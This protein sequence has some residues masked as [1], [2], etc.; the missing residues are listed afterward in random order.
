M[1]NYEGEVV[2][3]HYGRP[4]PKGVHGSINLPG[5]T[6]STTVIMQYMLELYDRIADKDL[7]VRRLNV[8]ASRV[9]P[10]K[11][12]EVMEEQASAFEQMELFTDYDKLEKDRAEKKEKM[13]REKN[14][15]KAVLEIKEKFGKNAVLKGMNLEK[16]GTTIERNRQIGGHKA[17]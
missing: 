12:A 5:F 11:K 9:I 13:K 16:G 17:E 14:V 8:V 7:T 2:F 10:E 3:D 4:I 6:S 15:Q 1:K